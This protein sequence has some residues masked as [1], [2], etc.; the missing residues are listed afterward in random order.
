MNFLSQVL[1]DQDWD[2]I[3]K[4]QRLGNSDF[5]TRCLRIPW[6]EDIVCIAIENELE[7]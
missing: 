5:Y 2:Q 3:Y 6:D 1:E 4:V 7:R